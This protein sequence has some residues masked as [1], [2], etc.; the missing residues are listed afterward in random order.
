MRVRK[1][2]RCG[3]G[4]T[5]T[6]PSTHMETTKRQS[7]RLKCLPP[8]RRCMCCRTRTMTATT[9]HRRH[10][11][12]RLPI[13]WISSG[14]MRKE[15]RRRRRSRA[16]AR[17]P[18][19]TAHPHGQTRPSARSSPSTQRSCQGRV[20]RCMAGP[21]GG[22]VV[23]VCVSLCVDFRGASGWQF[24]CSVLI[25][26]FLSPGLLRPTW[27]ASL[28]IDLSRSPIRAPPVLSIAVYASCACVGFWS[29]VASQW[30]WLAARR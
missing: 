11:P 30:P 6:T 29:F 23:R 25:V 1:C 4:R 12:T 5:C 18:P 7:L 22:F 15:R 9:L 17:R 14:R 16:T 3:S 13:R 10:P 19:P 8:A 20:N 28:P 24:C 26:S 27:P 2:I 21:R